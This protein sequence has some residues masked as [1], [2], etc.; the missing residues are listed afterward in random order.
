[1]HVVSVPRW[2]QPSTTRHNGGI[3]SQ[4]DTTADREMSG[5]SDV[6][7]SGGAFEQRHGVRVT[8]TRASFQF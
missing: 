8:C 2:A 4:A 1:M 5:D 7:E 6:G 3:I